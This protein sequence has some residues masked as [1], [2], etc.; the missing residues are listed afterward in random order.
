MKSYHIF[1]IAMAI[2]FLTMVSG[3]AAADTILVGDSGIADY[4]SIQAAI[5]AAS[6]G[7]TVLVHPG[8]YSENIDVD[9]ELTII[10]E[11]ENPDDTTVQAA[12]LNDHVFHVTANN[13]TISGFNVI[14]AANTTESG[15]EASG[16][17]IDGVSEF[18]LTNDSRVQNCIIKNNKLSN[19]N[20]GLFLMASNNNKLE[21][22][23]ASGNHFPIMLVF[24]NSSKLNNNVISDSEVGILM[25][26]GN[27]NLIANNNVSS[28][29]AG[30][31]TN[32]YCNNNTFINNMVSNNENGIALIYSGNNTLVNNTANSNKND[33]IYL[34]SSHSNMLRGNTANS[35]GEHGIYLDH[36]SNGNYVVNNTASNN[37]HGIRLYYYSDNNILVNNTA[38][39]N[40]QYGIYLN[41]TSNNRIEGNTANS[42]KMHGIYLK[43]STFNTIINNTAN[44]NNYHGIN[45]NQSNNKR[46]NTDIITP[47]FKYYKFLED[48]SNN[49]TVSGNYLVDNG[50]GLVANI[51]ENHI[52][53]NYVNDRDITKLPFFSSVL[54]LIILGIAFMIMRRE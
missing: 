54:T 50:K 10:A 12:D 43:S 49:N 39:S 52:G 18:V 53:I 14:G 24:T 46:V 32:Y 33:G 28:S 7:D 9:K 8:K 45:L 16:I 35:N 1:Y 21:N 31:G 47:D 13:V 25:F 27:D 44:L 22:N 15:T 6:N 51:T 29:G 11:S 17:Y 23:S 36:F 40:E 3:S 20:F 5:E 34:D 2:S 41:E 4:T 26:E 19:N 30:I 42:N 48:S 37:S 38:N